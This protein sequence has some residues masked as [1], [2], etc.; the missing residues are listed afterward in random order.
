MRTILTIFIFFL[1][2]GL[3]AQEQEILEI[4]KLY[5]E[6]LTDKKGYTV[7]TQDDFENSSEGGEITAYKNSKEVKLIEAVY[8]GHMGKAK[9]DYYYKGS[10]VYFVFVEE[11]NYNAP[12]TQPSYDQEKTTKDQS[13]YYFWNDEMIRWIKP[14]GEYSDTASTL[15]EE[16]STKILKW[17]SEMV[18]MMN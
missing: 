18:E 3:T 4:R 7:L 15:F 10:K 17:A 6:T 16:E 1:S 14:S 13:R 11:F 12:P 5:N 2:L 9:Y 8:Y